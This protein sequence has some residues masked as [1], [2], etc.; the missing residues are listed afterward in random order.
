MSALR[1][2][3]SAGSTLGLAVAAGILYAAGRARPPSPQ[4]VAPDPP[5]GLPPGRLVA[6]PGHGEFFV[7]EAAG[8]PGPATPTVALIHGWMFPSD[9][10]WLACYGP[11][12]EIAHVV[13]VDLRGHGRGPRPSEPFRLAGAA[14]D[15]AAVI[16]HLG[17]SPVVAVGYSMGGPVAQLLW[18]RHPHLV[19]GLV[20]CATSATFAA[21]WSARERWR[22]MGLFQVVLRL[23]P[24]HTRE[25]LLVAQ[26][27]GK[28]PVR[29]SRMVHE[30]TPAE[31]FDLLPWIVGELDRGSAEDIAEAGREMGRYDARGW[32]GGIDVPT[33]VLLTCRDALVPERDQRDLAARIPGCHV[34]EL[35]L[36]HD[37]VVARPDVF[38]PALLKAVEQVLPDERP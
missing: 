23:L 24:R 31:V 17:I 38:V 33:A 14:D 3:W 20:L 19:A 30:G 8:P 37:G 13:A 25:R 26:A 10:N 15:V 12:S 34:H 22:L 6:V 4:Q 28:L 27:R 21:D 1:Q 5:A 9:V 29:V 18:Q 36:D 11:L 16:E 35:P 32:I 7:R 2:V